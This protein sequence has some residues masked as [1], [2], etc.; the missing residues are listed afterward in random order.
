MSRAGL[1]WCRQQGWAGV[2]LD[3]VK[4]ECE[5]EL[6][7]TT[8]PIRFGWRDAVLLGWAAR[9]PV[10][11]HS[12]LGDRW[13]LSQPSVSRTV[14][15]W[16]EIGM[17]QQVNDVALRWPLE[18]VRPE[19][20]GLLGCL[21]PNRRPSAAHSAHSLGVL[22]E[23]AAAE[24]A[25]WR[26]ITERDLADDVGEQLAL[27]SGP[28]D[29][30]A[31]G[32]A[33]AAGSTGAQVGLDAL[34][35]EVEQLDEPTALAGRAVARRSVRPWWTISVQRADG[36]AGD[37]P[38]D[39]IFRRGSETVALEVELS[40]KAKGRVERILDA[41][42]RASVYTTVAYVVPRAEDASRIMSLNQSGPVLRC[43]ALVASTRFDWHQVPVE[44]SSL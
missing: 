33:G 30:D 38:P 35:A 17:C 41:Y 6:R 20:S 40:R 31:V 32:D 22:A 29:T 36:T 7:A 25:G 27:A 23:T 21:V 5:G 26:T 3:A 9:F 18:M 16:R 42:G 43:D 1:E 4:A 19:A 39:A 14:K 15:R 28:V 10:F 37:H 34:F 8:G 24:R 13:G 44:A 12:T 2:S 11:T